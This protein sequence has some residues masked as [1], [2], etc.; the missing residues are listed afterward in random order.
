MT[1]KITKESSNHCI[2]KFSRN[3][4]WIFLSFPINIGFLVTVYGNVADVLNDYLDLNFESSSL[5][6][7]YFN[8]S[9][10]QNP[11][12]MWNSNVIINRIE[13]CVIDFLESLFHIL[14]SEFL[15]AISFFLSRYLI[16]NLLS[17]WP[18]IFYH[19]VLLGYFVQPSCLY[20]QLSKNKIEWQ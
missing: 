8:I 10:N 4:H 18:S 9:Y 17:A 1:M 11:K 3:S 20:I 12:E 14:D 6:N 7:F 2:H 16:Q 13:R 19:L 15:V 5:S